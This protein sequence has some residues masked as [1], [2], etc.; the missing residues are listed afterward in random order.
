MEDLVMFPYDHGKRD[1]KK[2]AD[3]EGCDR[4]KVKN[5]CMEYFNYEHRLIYT[6]EG[7]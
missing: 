7:D 3:Y 2:R 4:D 1:G 6:L 5:Q